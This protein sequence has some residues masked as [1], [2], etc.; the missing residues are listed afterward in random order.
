MAAHISG[1]DGHLFLLYLAAKLQKKN[2]NVQLFL[3]F[4]HKKEHSFLECSYRD[5]G[6]RVYRVNFAE[7]E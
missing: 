3:C 5:L 2:P 6:D 4:E 7:T 1:I